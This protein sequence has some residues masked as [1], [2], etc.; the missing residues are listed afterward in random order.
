LAQ[1]SLTNGAVAGVSSEPH[2]SGH[3]LL[4]GGSLAGLSFE[5]KATT[6]AWADAFSTDLVLSREPLRSRERFCAA[7]SLVT[8][9]LLQESSEMRRERADD[10]LEHCFPSSDCRSRISQQVSWPRAMRA[11]QIHPRACRVA[12]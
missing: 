5:Q 12:P 1:L 4:T 6:Q 7:W 9:P 10:L 8:E 3:L 11:R 2:G